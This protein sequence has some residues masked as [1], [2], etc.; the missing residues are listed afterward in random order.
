ML[1]TRMISSLNE[2]CDKGESYN[3]FIGTTNLYNWNTLDYPSILS[4]IPTA[5]IEDAL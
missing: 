5:F 4:K 3:G 1:Q 2:A